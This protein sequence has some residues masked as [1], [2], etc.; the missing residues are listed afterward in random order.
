VLRE[1]SCGAE[2]ERAEP[3]VAAT[4]AA[5]RAATARATMVLAAAARTPAAPS[6]KPA[7][8]ASPSAPT[9]A[10]PTATATTRSTQIT[11]A[12]KSLLALSGLRRVAAS[13]SSAM[14][15]PKDQASTQPMATPTS[16]P[17]V[18]AAQRWLANAKNAAN[19]HDDLGE[20]DR[21]INLNE[22]E[23]T[24]PWKPRAEQDKPRTAGVHSDSASAAEVARRELAAHRIQ[25]AVARYL[26]ALVER[27]SLLSAARATTVRAAAA[28][29]Q[30]EIAE[31]RAEAVMS[32]AAADV[33]VVVG[34]PIKN[35]V[36][37][38]A[39]HRIQY[40]V[41]AHFMWSRFTCSPSAA[42]R[43][44]AAQVAAAEARRR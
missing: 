11:D 25:Y 41:A 20:I 6:P 27:A 17:A 18:H 8:S 37:E 22:R 34:Q 13:V 36:R 19:T 40:A 21:S 12:A 26:V 24:S 3:T 10:A 1:Q 9:P 30:A 33:V 2:L 42:G 7:T 32:Y 31:A 15:V 38:A 14:L 16:K 4:V 5:A 28:E 23:P 44:A 29:A 39:A 35:A 43:A